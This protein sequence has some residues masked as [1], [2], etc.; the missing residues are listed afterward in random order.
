MTDRIFSM[1]RFGTL[2]AALTLSACNW[3]GKNDK[4]D[5]ANDGDPEIADALNDQILVDGN[6]D[7]QSN[8]N[9]AR[10]PAAPGNSRYPSPEP[11]T[12]G[13]KG[14]DA[15]AALGSNCAD[16]DRFDYAMRWKDRLAP[17]FQVYP[18]GSVTE[19]AANNQAGCRTR[20]VAFTSNDD[21]KPIIAWYQ[22]LAAGAGYSAEPAV[23]DGDHVLGG[24][25]EKDDG[26]YYLIVTPRA[27]GSEV[28]L[29]ANN[30]R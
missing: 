23:R 14:N 28:V 5:A 6:L 9:G 18:G 2:A 11:G 19:A 4:V 27:K 29:I 1:L 3:L 24:A 10:T 12:P 22:K 13:A 25:R 21:W 8:R 30:G 15:V 20:V 26:A 17:P 16:K 7:N